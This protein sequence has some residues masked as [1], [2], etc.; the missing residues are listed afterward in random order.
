MI[1]FEK[2]SVRGATKQDGVCIEGCCGRKTGRGISRAR[3]DYPPAKMLCGTFIARCTIQ[4]YYKTKVLWTKV[5][6]GQRYYKT[7]VLFGTKSD[8]YLKNLI[9]EIL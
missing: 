5:L 9:L 3:Q 2:I 1:S 7:K 4:R 6:F 8:Q